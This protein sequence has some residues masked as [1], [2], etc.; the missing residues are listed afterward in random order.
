MVG[1]GDVLRVPEFRA[2]FGG[3][4]LTTAGKTMQQ[5]ALASLV[6]AVTRSPLLS[7]VAFLAGLLPQA[8]VALTVMSLA[9]RLPPRAALTV[10]EAVRAV[11]LCG[12]ALD[13]L[14]VRAVLLAILFLGAGDAV[15]VAVRQAVLADVLGRD[16]YVPGRALLNIVVGVMQILGFAAGGVLVTSAGVSGAL[17][18]AALAALGAAGVSWFGL[19]PRPSRGPAGAVRAAVRA[20]WA[21]NRTLFADRRTRGL[22]LAHWLPNGL[23]VGAEALY[24]PYAGDTAGSL[25]V[26][27]G[28][29]MLLGDVVVGRLTPEL[30]GRLILPLSLLLAV[31]YLAF[32]VIPPGPG[33]LAAV[34]VASFGFGST[35]GVQERLVLAMPERLCGQG[36]GL[37]MSGMMTTQ[38]VAASLTGTVAEITSTGTAMALA[39]A[40]SLL[41]TFALVAHVGPRWRARDRARNVESTV[42][43]SRK[44]GAG[45]GEKT[46]DITEE[47]D[48]P[49]RCHRHARARRIR[50]DRLTADDDDAELESAPR[51]G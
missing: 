33:A 31:P 29:G 48:G 50:V 8:I 28:A 43:Y 21:G 18:A 11:T 15:A 32:F 45:I 30:R 6:F 13:V 46:S 17:L 7:A 9:D 37:A 19:R 34:A 12:L 22:L 16:Q 2:L 47:I 3:H 25:F 24:V 14:P 51:S 36:L 27:A 35:L 26:A 23:V 49:V 20:T 1:Y 39:G 4:S 41:L 40:G 5:L 38:A 10:W 42:N 44:S